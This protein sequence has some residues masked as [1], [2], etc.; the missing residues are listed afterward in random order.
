MST[1]GAKSTPQDAFWGAFLVLLRELL[2]GEEA[3]SFLGEG[4]AA[5]GHG[6]EVGRAGRECGTELL[7]VVVEAD[8]GVGAVGVD[9][10]LLAEGLAL[11]AEE[12]ADVV[13]QDVLGVAAGGAVFF[14][15]KQ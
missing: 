3:L 12:T 10:G 6:L 1:F 9:V 14:L 4:D 7:R 13:R 5:L 11:A 8:L 2:L 15:H